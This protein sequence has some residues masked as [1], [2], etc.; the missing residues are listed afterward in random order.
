M[1]RAIALLILATLFIGMLVLGVVSKMQAQPACSLASLNGSYGF[2]GIAFVQG[3]G[4]PAAIVASFPSAA[5][6]IITFDGAGGFSQESPTQSQNGTIFPSGFFGTFTG[7]YTVNPNCTGSAADAAG[8]TFGFVI[9]AEGREL[10]ATITANPF[11]PGFLGNFVGIRM[12]NRTCSVASLNGS[13]G[14]SGSGFFQGTG[15]AAATFASRPRAAVGIVTFDGAGGAS[16]ELTGSVNGTVQSVTDT[17]TYA[18]NSNCTGSIS[19]PVAIGDF[20]IVAEGKTILAIS[21]VPG[22]V[23]TIVGIRIR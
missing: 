10:R 2:S 12:D 4:A 23:V 16:V 19:V 15:A 9:A 7:T 17:G 6:G 18:V 3:T 20:V 8:E 21:T 13:Y 1:K 5:V 22:E 11:F 14:F